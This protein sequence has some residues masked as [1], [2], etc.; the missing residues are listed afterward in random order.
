MSNFLWKSLLAGPAVLGAAFV[1]SGSA[2][3]AESTNVDALEQ[4]NDYNSGASVELAQVTSVQEL[5]DVRPSDWAFTALQRLVEE[6]GCIEGFPNRTYRG[7]Q[8]MTRYE[9]AAGLNACL[10]VM[11]QL[12]GSGQ[13]DSS[14]LATIRRLQEEFQS[15][16]A[17]LRGRVDSLEADVAELEANQFSTTTKLRGQV[18]AHVNVPFDEAQNG[19]RTTFEYRAR[20]NFDTSFTGEDRLRLRLQSGNNNGAPVGFPGGFADSNGGFSGNAN[21]IGFDD[22]YYAFPLGDRIDVIV[23]GNSIETDDFVTSTIVPFDGPSVGDGGL[24][25]L[26]GFGAEGGA[27]LGVSVA[28]TDN[29]VVDAGYSVDSDAIGNPS[30]Q[31]IFSGGPQSYIGQL[32]YLSDGLIDAG[33]VYIHGT[34]EVGGL[35]TNTYGGLV[36]LD[37]GRFMVGGAIAF[38][39][40]ESRS[41]D[42]YSWQAGVALPDFWLEGSTLGVYGGQA[43]TYD[44]DE[45]FF[46]EGFYEVPISEYLTITPAVLYAE[47]NDI[48]S[49]GLEDSLYGVIRATFEF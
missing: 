4:I 36:N 8:A 13:T 32:S 49:V 12:I 41:D 25:Y 15:E 9:F 39:E 21:D 6:Y 26:Y 19:E 1:V 46:V 31:G 35:A 48:N 23:A 17:T 47:E 3:A 24:P 43:P 11:L 5:S 2:L 29:I 44:G 18:T 30:G 27:G 45:P 34:E 20:L 37:F 16:L 7:N 40:L 14:E 38:H 28:L 42:T 10:D 33:L 22:V